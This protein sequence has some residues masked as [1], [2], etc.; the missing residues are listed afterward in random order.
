TMMETKE[1]LLEIS[2]A[3][4]QLIATISP[5]YVEYFTA[6]SNISEYSSSGEATTPPG[7][8]RVIASLAAHGLSTVSRIYHVDSAY[9]T[10]PLYQRALVMLAPSPAHLCKSVIM[11]NKRWK[12][13]SAGGGCQYYCVLVQYTQTIDTGALTDFVR[14]GVAR[15]NFNFRLSDRSLEL[16][17][18][19]NNAVCPLGMTSSSQE[20]GMPVVLCEA[21]TS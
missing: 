2:L 9:Y 17:G 19:E 16:T 14:G 7:V 12:P 6:Q 15:K 21:I 8:L 13:S 20:E 10:W 5:Q 1:K 11:E 4:S 3:A 18:F